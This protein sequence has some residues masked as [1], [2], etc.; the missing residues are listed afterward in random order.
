MFDAHLLACPSCAGADQ[1]CAAGVALFE[2][3]EFDDTMEQ[4]RARLHDPRDLSAEPCCPDCCDCS[5]A[6]G[7]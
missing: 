3:Q 6:E 2:Q 4:H 7:V 5:Q 1:P